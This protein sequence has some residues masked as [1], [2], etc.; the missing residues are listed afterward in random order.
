MSAWKNQ[1]G[2]GATRIACPGFVAWR[3]TKSWSWPMPTS[4]IGWCMTLTI[5][6]KGEPMRKGKTPPS[7]K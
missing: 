5:E 2:S 3:G 4:W 7:E 1:T 6:I